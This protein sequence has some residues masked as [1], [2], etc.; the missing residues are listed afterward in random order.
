MQG[1]NLRTAKH[2]HLITAVHAH[3]GLLEGKHLPDRWMSVRFEE[4]D[5]DVGVLVE[6]CGVDDAIS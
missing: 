6:A 1:N 5:Q 4:F 3:R 2:T